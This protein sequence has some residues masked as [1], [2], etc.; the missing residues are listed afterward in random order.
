MRVVL[1]TLDT[2]RYDALLPDGHPDGPPDGL[3]ADG[4]G[5]PMPRLL[6]RARDGA[7]FERFYAATSVTQPSHASMLTGLH[8]W[9]HGVTANGQVLDERFETVAEVLR[10]AGFA[11]A[12]V[13][14]SFPVASRFGFAQGFDSFD[15]RFTESPVDDRRWEGHDVP[16]DR[17]YSLADTV[18][19]RALALLE[20][21]GSGPERPRDGFLWVH[22]F[23][24][25]DPYGDTG[26][27]PRYHP[28]R[29]RRALEEGR[30][31]E[32]LLGRFRS[33]Y[34]RDAAFLDRQLHRLLDTLAA[35][36]DRFETHVVLA[37]DHGESFGEEGALAHGLRLTD[38]QIRVPLVILSPRVAPGRRR[39]VAGSV[40]VAPTLLALAGVAVDPGEPGSR[41]LPRAPSRPRDLTAAP[42]RGPSPGRALGMRRTFP[43]ERRTEERTEL[44]TDGS[45]HALP[46][47]LFYAV[48][49]GGRV[50]RG[51][52][53]GLAGKTQDADPDEA[54]RWTALFREL[55]GRV[56]AGGAPDAVDPQALEALR[57]LGY[58][59]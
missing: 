25:H 26:G 5:S 8:P 13:V 47:Y 9:E 42:D 6:E 4:G 52:G 7:L 55:E 33:A 58:V 37:S 18:T 29:A 50:V 53:A 24:P 20:A 15:D 38:E 27:G 45:R 44:R 39:D 36:A 57:A 51:N 56:E 35:G 2:L 3:S 28:G 19:D 11:T 46:R 22:Y 32:P 12:A 40:D 59:E 49:P 23:D 31:V 14:A 1:V 54:R 34:D 10:E 30:D 16:E 41:S 43:D 21:V 48:D 17:F